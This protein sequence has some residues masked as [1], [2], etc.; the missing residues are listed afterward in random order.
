MGGVPVQCRYRPVQR[1][2]SGDS[3]KQEYS[4]AKQRTAEQTSIRPPHHHSTSQN[5]AL[6]IKIVG[7]SRGDDERFFVVNQPVRTPTTKITFLAERGEGEQT[8]TKRRRKRPRKMNRTLNQLRVS[9]EKYEKRRTHPKQ[10]GEGWGRAEMR[11]TS[12]FDEINETS[13]GD[14]QKSIL[15][16]IIWSQG[17]VRGHRTT[18]HTTPNIRRVSTA[19]SVESFE[20]GGFDTQS[21]TQSVTTSPHSIPPISQVSN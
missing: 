14:V 15:R 8:V 18:N 10:I 21:D 4:S 6:N 9:T 16:K 7:P 11:G 19:M 13:F 20:R 2:R 17:A 1:N 12:H 5:D 3:E